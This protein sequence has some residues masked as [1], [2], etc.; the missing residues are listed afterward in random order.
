MTIKTVTVGY[1]RLA[2]GSNFSNKRY[3]CELTAEMRDGDH[4]KHF[5]DELL[6][7]CENYVESK[8]AGEEVIVVTKNQGEKIKSL[9]QS[10]NDL[11]KDDLPF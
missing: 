5:R 8:F 10:V 2:T 1:S 7:M 3:S 11:K 6:K 9:V 4:W